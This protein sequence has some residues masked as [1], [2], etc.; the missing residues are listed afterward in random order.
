MKTSPFNI[1][2]EYFFV[3]LGSAAMGLG[4]VLFFIGNKI[5]P[6]GLTG[7]ATVIY[8]FTGWSVGLTVILMNLPLLLIASF[9]LG[10]Q[11][12]IKTIFGMVSYSLFLQL[13]SKIPPLT[14]DPVLAV[15]FGG[16]LVGSG[17][18]LVFRQ[19]ST[20]GGTDLAARI[21]HRINPAFS[22]GNFLF[23]F[24]AS[25]VVISTLAF[26]NYELGLYAALAIF[27]ISRI[28][29]VVILGVDYTKAVYIISNQ[30]DRIAER[31]LHELNRGVTEIQG[32]GKFTGETRN[33]LL[34]VM[35]PKY[36]V[37]V[38]QLVQQEDPEAFVFI[39]DVRDV[40]GQGFRPY[41]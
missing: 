30:S 33:I 12:G 6:G 15:L 41:L 32:V 39:S 37:K 13:F 27:A 8:H 9:L 22:I 35:R 38:K 19:G 14:N 29:D 28:V 16:L 3:T 4:Y 17:S 26:K 34:S 36:I 18:G 25:V 20:V 10:K 40:M 23:F 31:M 21:L 24:D 5:A 7:L 2:K 1:L 11:I